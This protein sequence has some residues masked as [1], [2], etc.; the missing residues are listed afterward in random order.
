MESVKLSYYGRVEKIMKSAGFQDMGKFSRL[1]TDQERFGFLY[2]VDNVNKQFSAYVDDP[3]EVEDVSKSDKR[4]KTLREKG[5]N[6]YKLG[7]VD[8]AL[9]YYNMAVLEAR[10]SAEY[11]SFNDDYQVE[12]HPQIDSFNENCEEKRDKIESET[13]NLME[14]AF[15]LANRSACLLHLQQNHSNKHPENGNKFRFVKQALRDIR[16]AI[17][18]GYP[19]IQRHKLI[20]RKIKCLKTIGEKGKFLKQT[21]QEYLN[22]LEVC[23]MDKAKKDEIVE[24]TKLEIT[25]IPENPLPNQKLSNSHK[26]C[27]NKTFINRTN[28]KFSKNK[29]HYIVLEKEKSDKQT[30]TSSLAHHNDP[31]KNTNILKTGSVV[32]KDT[33]YFKVLDE[34]FLTTKC[35]LCYEAINFSS[36]AIVPCIT[37][38]K[39]IF[40]SY[41]CRNISLKVLDHLNECFLIPIL[42][43]SQTGSI[44]KLALCV[45][46][47]VGVHNWMSIIEEDGSSEM[48]NNILCEKN[49]TSTN[50]TIGDENTDVNFIKSKIYKDAQSIFNLISHSEKRAT[51]DSLQY[52]LLSIYIVLLVKK[53]T[54]ILEN[55]EK[56]FNKNDGN[57]LNNSGTI[58]KLNDAKMLENDSLSKKIGGVV[59][60][61]LQIISCNG[62]EITETSKTNSTDTLF[63]CQP[64]KVA[65]ALYP[66]ASFFNHSCFPDVEFIFEKDSLTAIT[67][68]PTFNG[69]ELTVDYGCLF[70]LTPRNERQSQLKQQY[71]FD[72]KCQ[73]CL[74]SWPLKN[75]LKMK[76]TVSNDEIESKKKL[77]GDTTIAKSDENFEKI[78]LENLMKN[79]M[80][81]NLLGQL[82]NLVASNLGDKTEMPVSDDEFDKLM[83]KSLVDMSKMNSKNKMEKNKKQAMSIE[84]AIEKANKMKIDAEVIE[85]LARLYMNVN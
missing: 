80:S 7:E 28:V 11:H 52:C 13:K 62:I 1:K 33:T 42:S 32:V 68:K 79:N 73:A 75:L 51:M 27:S 63:N 5:N 50:G 65:L 67:I 19:I 14:M 58:S 59:L 16:D 47:G 39:V 8:D 77:N 29:G 34:D 72:C 44:S 40:C 30:S 85:T 41:K 3:G 2:S 25:S 70:H 78:S 24:K 49:A 9:K 15:C 12:F 45:L 31:P 69:D 82:S 17:A 55:L 6:K 60:K 43:A 37:C 26:N 23:E 35:Y 48:K 53:K 38:N 46:L 64:T 84:E 83:K 74:S 61:I 71:F 10:V 76:A 22:S 81:K 18:H 57:S 20:E 4:A 36:Q 21:L 54:K 56:I 66:Y